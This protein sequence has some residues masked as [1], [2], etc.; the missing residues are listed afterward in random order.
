MFLELL[1][2]F[3]PSAGEEFDAADLL[4]A[5]SELRT[6]VAVLMRTAVKPP[7]K[8][9]LTTL[10]ARWKEISDKQ[11]TSLKPTIPDLRWPLPPAPVERVPAGSYRFICFT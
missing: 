2:S 4:P 3:H 9:N 8:Q 11:E 1:L 7:V 5:T 6:K 10:E